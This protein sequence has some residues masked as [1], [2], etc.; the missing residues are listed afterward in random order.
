M[1]PP[2]AS[3]R[4]KTLVWVSNEYSGEDNV[5]E[6]TVWVGPDFNPQERALY[7]AQVIETPRLDGQPMMR[8]VSASEGKKVHK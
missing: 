3:F 2:S 7:C 4:L 5:P 8:F 6:D 1:P